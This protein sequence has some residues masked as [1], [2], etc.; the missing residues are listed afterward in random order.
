M[1]KQ[2][3]SK[4]DED[5]F[6]DTFDARELPW[7]EKECKQ[8]EKRQKKFD[9]DCKEVIIKAKKKRR[10]SELKEISNMYGST[11]KKVFDMSTTTKQIMFFLLLNCTVVE[12]YSMIVIWRFGDLSALPAFITAAVT[13]TISFAVYC[14]KSYLETKSEKNLEFETKKLGL[15]VSTKVNENEDDEEL[16]DDSLPDDIEE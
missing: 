16:V 4:H 13:E 15:D 11:R 5:T 8:E 7:S 12:I 9:E 2:I 10:K 6:L 14:V 3:F 1:N